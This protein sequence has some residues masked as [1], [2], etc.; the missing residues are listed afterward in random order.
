MIK[1]Q[2]EDIPC[3]TDIPTGIFERCIQAGGA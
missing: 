1:W 2:E 3:P